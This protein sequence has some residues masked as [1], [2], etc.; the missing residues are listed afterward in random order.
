MFNI[1]KNATKVKQQLSR[2]PEK[3]WQN[4]VTLIE[5][6][7]VVTILLFLMI[8]L[9]RS[10]SRHLNKAKDAERKKDLQTIKVAFEDYFNDNACYPDVDALNNCGSTALQPWLK[11]IPCDPLGDA[12]LYLPVNDASGNPCAGYRVLT[13]LAISDDPMIERVGCPGGCGGVFPPTI[14]DPESYNYGI[15][16]GVALNQSTTYVAPTMAVDCNTEDCY[17]CP[18]PGDSC[19][20]YN[21]GDPCNNGPFTNPQECIDA[22]C[23]F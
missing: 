2:K 12:Y 8:V 6:V 9:Y 1:A 21:P 10:M 14:T 3:K 23:H 4:G 19:N 13:K 15:A 5:L 11:N 17:C 18:A 16:E 7:V 20:L 22:G